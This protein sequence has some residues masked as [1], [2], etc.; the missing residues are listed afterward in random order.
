MIS[1]N[2]VTFIV[3]IYKLGIDRLNNLKFILPHIIKTGARVLVVEQVKESATSLDLKEFNSEHLLY[4]SK[5]EEFHKTGIINWAVKNHA[6][7]K[8]VWVNDVDFYM[9][10]NNV[11]GVE[12]TEDFIKPYSTGKK[13]TSD[14]STRILRG[15]KLNVSY[16][17]ESAEYISL[18]GA[19]SFIFEKN[20][21]L[22]IGGMDES[23]FG[24]GKEDIE[25]DRRLKSKNIFVQ[26]MDHK[27]IHLWHDVARPTPTPT[28]SAALTATPTI[29]EEH[30]VIDINLYFDQIYCLNLKRRSDRWKIVSAEFK[31]HGICVRRFNAI[32]K[33][34]LS[35]ADVRFVENNKKLKIPLS[36][37]STGAL[38][39]LLSHIEIIKDAKVNGFNKILI[40]E[41]DVAISE[42]FK[43][44]IQ[45]IKNLPWK[46][47]Y[48]GASQ[49]DW[50]N[51]T[52]NNGFYECKNTLGTFAWAINSSIY[53]EIIEVALTKQKPVDNLISA[54]QEKY[55]SQC[56]TF[57]PNIVIA[58]VGESDIREN[59]N[60]E[61]Y[62]KLV[63][64]DLTK[65]SN[66][67]A[68]ENHKKL[69]ENVT[70]LVKSF[71]RKNCVEN[72]ILS[73]R[74]FYPTI[75]IIIVDDSNPPLQFDYPNV[76]TYNIEFDSGV[77]AGR[78]FGVSKVKTKYFVLLDDDF[79]FTEE[80]CLEKFYEIIERNDVDVLGGQVLE[81]KIAVQYYG[82]FSI[83]EKN[84]AVVTE[85]GYQDMGD[86][87]QSHLILNFFIAK[88]EKIKKFGWDNKLKIAEHAA[89]FFEHRDK[90][91]VGYLDNVS[92]VHKQLR[93]ATYNTYR[94]RAMDMFNDWIKR[95]NINYYVNFVNVLTINPSL[96]KQRFDKWIA[97]KNL[98]DL[99]K[100]L[101]SFKVPYWLQD[102]TL[103]GYVR[104]KDFIGHDLDT[105]IG[106]MFSDFSPE[107]LAAIKSNG[108][109]IKHTFGYPQNSFE[110]SLLRF[111]IKTDIFFFYKQDA[112]LY[113]CAFKNNKRIDYRY[114]PFNTKEITFLDHNFFVP[115]NEMEYVI[116][117]YGTNWKT[118]IKE[119]DWAYSPVNHY[120]TGYLVDP[121]EQKKIVEK[122]MTEKSAPKQ[123]NVI[124]YGTFDTFH[125]GHIELLHRAKSFGN[126]LI[127]GL[128]TDSFNS[129]KNKQSKFSYNHRKK[130]LESLKIVD[131]IIPETS[132]NQKMSDIKKYDVHV[133]IMG[134]DW[135]GKFDHL[136]C[137]VIYLKRTPEISSTK[138]KTIT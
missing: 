37:K 113:H 104:E 59:R 28:P 47:L 22:N 94:S 130:W 31:K 17:D 102:G 56:Y 89:F 2:D 64:W 36:I 129:E 66:V 49:F 19:L 115:V 71:I 79:E 65:F 127:V 131:Q 112:F 34:D 15:E 80:T 98:S 39:C 119:W 120:D 14:D 42:D 135:V 122:W 100:I 27:G 52:P 53:D 1:A 109:E 61:Y 128:S 87:K 88:T 41:D 46:L 43:N 62:A 103:L 45:D 3:P 11:F 111:N 126:K 124:T 72:L 9:K 96:P 83:D 10:F 108:F 91:K 74:K 78:N 107:V 106:I 85:R 25:F 4:V 18:Y 132:W 13:L 57:F 90:L 137:R 51:I 136:E 63:K 60:V 105:D 118:P 58:E 69:N 29:I 7:T 24:W 95:K 125:Y 68:I 32:D 21:F 99:D 121:E 50:E 12:W 23:L 35:I 26:E 38:A 44:K 93:D 70:L 110:I 55:K 82:Y 73:I 8:Y 123:I 97:L 138:I 92:I 114:T 134:D 81:K 76:E 67:A 5:S 16:E 30:Q 133:L 77:S 75:Q 20:A 117:K 86:Y 48:L 101:R 33:K 40:F 54:L 6:N 116:T 84:K